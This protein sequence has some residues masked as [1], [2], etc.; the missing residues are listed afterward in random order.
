MKKRII[1]MLLVVVM[2]VSML[3]VAFVTASAASDISY[4]TFI[5]NEKITL[6]GKIDDIYKLST[7]LTS[8]F[9]P[10]G[11]VGK[12]TG[13][14][15][16]VVGTKDG[17]YVWATIYD[18][19]L[20]KATYVEQGVRNQDGDKIQIALQLGNGRWARFGYIDFD[21]VNGGRNCVSGNFG[22]KIENIDQKAILWEDG[23]G[24]DIECYIPWNASADT[25]EN[26][27]NLVCKIGIQVSNDTPLEW[28]APDAATNP[29][30]VTEFDRH[31]LAYTSS[32]GYSYY[33]GPEYLHP[34]KFVATTSVY[35]VG[36]PVY[37]S[38]QELGNGTIDG[39]KD[40]DYGNDSVAI[41]INVE[42]S[43][44]NPKE[45]KAWV[46]FTDTRL[47]IFVQVEDDYLATDT[48]ACDAIELI[49]HFPLS[50]G[51]TKMGYGYGFKDNAGH[52]YTSTDWGGA[53]EWQRPK[54]DGN[55]ENWWRNGTTTRD[56]V[57]GI[58]T[59]EVKI[60]LP[61][62]EKAALAAGN[63]V[64]VCIGIRHRNYDEDGSVS[65][66]RN[67]Y[68]FDWETIGTMGNI[69]PKYTLSK[70]VT[71]S[72]AAVES[73]ITGANVVLNE[74][75]TVNYYAN[76][77]STVKEPAMKFTFNE[78]VTF[79]KGVPTTTANE[80][81]FA[82]EG[83]APQCMGDNIKAALYIDGNVIDTFDEYS[84]K[85]NVTSDD[86]YTEENK[87]L[88]DALLIYGAAAQ[89]YTNYKA[90]NLVVDLDNFEL[91]TI[92]DYTKSAY[93]EL[94]G[95]RFY[96]AGV[97]YAN[98]NKIFVKIE[99]DDISKVKSL[100]VRVGDG[101]P[102]AL[103]LTEVE[104]GIYIAYTDAIKATGFNDIHTFIITD[105]NDNTRWL[106]YSVNA[107]AKAMQANSKNPNTVTLVEALYNYGREAS[108][109]VK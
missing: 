34:I 96:S 7:P 79:V 99:T 18:D 14:T 13:F 60:D 68:E 97:H 27:L 10:V 69:L 104:D 95:I 81:K 44:N 40:S 1:P 54:T 102:V 77:P 16:Y 88:V 36:N 53:A 56:T 108:K 41:P 82:F 93:G 63:D 80:Y 5:T 37:A 48:V 28:N 50:N 92:V 30:K 51:Q 59:F 109:L 12:T 21:Y 86:V 94:E 84:V 106:S 107:Y 72:N 91:G 75:I 52:C 2:V 61:Q 76:V 25:K 105:T 85:S 66:T 6:D 100:T 29:G 62:A 4:E 73:K 33:V 9:V 101:D 98:V 45:G 17:I 74:S 65:Y 32:N 42:K 49:I 71:A 43:G 15:A 46:A 20:T 89:K 103:E 8:D 55:T 22:G 90:D 64:E 23:K 35:N 19:T 58:Y 78:K 3:P 24:W 31:G 11:E 38:N 47:N 26:L 70:S 67:G 39:V 87:A 83:I 57:N